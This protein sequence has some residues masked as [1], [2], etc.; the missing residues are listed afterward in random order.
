VLSWSSKH[1]ALNAY[2]LQVCIHAFGLIGCTVSVSRP[3]RPS[4]RG[5]RTFNFARWHANSAVRLGLE[6]SATLA[7]WCLHVW[8]PYAMFV[9]ALGGGGRSRFLGISRQG[10]V[11][12][13]PAAAGLF[14]AARSHKAQNTCAC[15]CASGAAPAPGVDVLAR[16]LV[17]ASRPRR[18]VLFFSF[19]SLFVCFGLYIYVMCLT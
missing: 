16:G 6:K 4:I 14:R 2:I 5:A 1:A 15:A 9:A 10:G 19:F 3:V 7:R 8:M 12:G 18:F 17:G 13:G 11:W